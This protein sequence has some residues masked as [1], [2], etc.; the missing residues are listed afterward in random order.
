MLLELPFPVLSQML[1]DEAM[2]TAAVEKALRALHLAQEPRYRNEQEVVASFSFLHH[3][4]QA[5]LRE[6][7]GPQKS[8]LS[9]QLHSQHRSAVVFRCRE[10]GLL[11]NY[12]LSRIG[13][14]N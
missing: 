2:L 13:S 6:Y 8:S 12:I 1:Q 7:V 11:Y 10:H 14:L 4:E 5:D 3:P 9:S